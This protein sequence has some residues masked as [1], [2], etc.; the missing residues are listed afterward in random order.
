MPDDGVE[1]F[2]ML[3]TAMGS[4]CEIDIGGLRMIV[5]EQ[6]EC[7]NVEMLRLITLEVAVDA[8]ET[9]VMNRVTFIRVF[10]AGKYDL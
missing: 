1:G 2:L 8:L 6:V 10:H 7:G 5:G 4:P 9:Y 3:G